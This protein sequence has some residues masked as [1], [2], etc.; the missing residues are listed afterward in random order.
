ML[1]Q[2]QQA[3]DGVRRPAG[4]DLE[5]RV[6]AVR[7]RESRVERERPGKR[8]FCLR[9][10][11]VAQR[12]RRRV[13]GNQTVT[14]RQPRP[15][16]C[17]RRLLLDARLV[18]VARSLPVVSFVRR[19]V[20]AR[21]ELLR[22]RGAGPVTT[23]RRRGRIVAAIDVHRAHE[24][25]ASTRDRLDARR[26]VAI[27]EQPAKRRHV[28]GQVRVLDRGI[29]PDQVQQRLLRQQSAGMIEKHDEGIEHPRRDGNRLAIARQLLFAGVDPKAP[30]PVDR[31][32]SSHF[33]EIF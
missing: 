2:S 20:G 17:E 32:G 14:P 13:L 15:R 9:L 10:R 26:R 11:D 24:T 19:L 31:R 27:G 8:G 23:R 22:P 18:E 6:E 3:E 21:V 29:W 25:I 16:R 4:V 28:D 30:K 1:N 7:Q 33:F 5:L 12:A